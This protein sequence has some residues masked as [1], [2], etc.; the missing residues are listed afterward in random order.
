MPGVTYPNL[1]DLLPAWDA[2]LG[3]EV[4]RCTGHADAAKMSASQLIASP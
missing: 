4:G 1:I 2:D 3:H